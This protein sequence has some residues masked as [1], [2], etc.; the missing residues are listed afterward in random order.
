MQDRPQRRILCCSHPPRTSEATLLSVPECNL[1][2]QM[3]TLRSDI[4]TSGLHKSAE[5]PGG[6]CQKTG[7]TDMNLHRRHVNSEFSEGGSSER[8]LFDDSPVRVRPSFPGSSTSTGR[9]LKLTLQ[10]AGI[11]TSVLKAHSTRGA[12]SSAARQSAVSVKDILAA[13]DWSREATINHFYYCPRH[14]ASFSAVISYMSCLEQD[15]S[16]N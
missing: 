4:S 1:P 10:D 14:S 9:C 12:S 6:V 5:A 7:S 8:C 13:A 11:D 3:P 15:Q 2:V 16:V